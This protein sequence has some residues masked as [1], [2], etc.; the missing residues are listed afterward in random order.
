LVFGVVARVA[1]S[2]LDTT[3]GVAFGASALGSGSLAWGASG[4]TG[5]AIGVVAGWQKHGG[6]G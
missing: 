4:L 1:M 6:R 5:A 3:V 2:I